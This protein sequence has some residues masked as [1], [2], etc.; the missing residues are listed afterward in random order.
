MPWKPCA[1]TAATSRPP[2]PKP[3]QPGGSARIVRH[4]ELH[5]LTIAHLDCDAFYATIEKRDRR[6]LRDV[7]VVVGGY[8]RGVVAAC[9]YIARAQGV[10]SAMPM[11][12]AL[13]ACPDATVISG[14]RSR[15]PPS[16]ERGIAGHRRRR[17]FHRPRPRQEA[18]GAGSPREPRRPL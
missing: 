16:L 4:K 9:C 2:M 18:A 11:F 7:P 8:H 13:K 5:S 10:H 14:A 3:A 17:G 15:S 1:V 12:K 6:E